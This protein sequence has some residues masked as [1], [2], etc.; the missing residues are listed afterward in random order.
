MRLQ[1]RHATEKGKRVLRTSIN[2]MEKLAFLI[3]KKE[4]VPVEKVNNTYVK[5]MLA[6]AHHHYLKAS[7]AWNRKKI[8]RAEKDLISS[9]Y[10][11][12]RASRWAK[13]DM[14]ETINALAS[15]VEGFY[16]QVLLKE[17]VS[18]QRMEARIEEFDKELIDV[19]K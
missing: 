18:L 19:R 7:T 5:A 14:K 10:Y 17:G 16:D 13:Q 8:D 1:S 2:R 3:E 6:L 12:R 9:A 4:E 11:L 15:E